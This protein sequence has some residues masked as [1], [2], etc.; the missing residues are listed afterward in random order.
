[1]E[2]WDLY[3]IDRVK[4]GETMVRGSGYNN[5][6]LH[7]VVH[8]CIFNTQ[9]EMLIQQRQPFK[10]GWSNLWD[11]TVGGSAVAGDTSQTAVER[12]LFEELGLKLNLQGVRPHLTIN[13]EHGFDDI[14]LIEKEVELST[15]SLQY[16]EVQDAKWAS[17]DEI[18]EKIDNGQFIPYH[19]SIIQLFFDIRKQFGAINKETK[20]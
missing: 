12:E 16:E 15:L 20:R 17:R 13:F 2:I 7:L 19:K 1:M 10:E 8:A 5:G 6:A 3:D 18:F 11:I 14:Y 4:N 9:G